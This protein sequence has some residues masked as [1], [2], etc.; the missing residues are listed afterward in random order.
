MLY[1]ETSGI[2]IAEINV[3]R[4]LTEPNNDRDLRLNSE[5]LSHE[6]IRDFFEWMEASTTLDGW[7]YRRSRWQFV[8]LLNKLSRATI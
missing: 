6:D 3:A 5:S 4:F 2:T 1:R 7:Q 8:I